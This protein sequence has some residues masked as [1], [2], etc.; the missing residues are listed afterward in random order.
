MS[1]LLLEEPYSLWVSRSSWSD[2]EATKLKLPYSRW[3]SL[4]LV[5]IFAE[6]PVFIGDWSVPKSVSWVALIVAGGLALFGLQYNSTLVG[7]EQNGPGRD[8]S[9]L[10]SAIKPANRTVRITQGVRRRN[11]RRRLNLER[12][13]AETEVMLADLGGTAQEIEATLALARRWL[14]AYR[15]EQIAEVKR[16]LVGEDKLH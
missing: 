7:T 16:W 15:D 3:P 8:Q 14:Q 1:L 2:N 11:Q 6:W 12:Q 4:H 9:N 5:R 13:L 10:H